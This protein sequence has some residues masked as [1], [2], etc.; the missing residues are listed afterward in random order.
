MQQGHTGLQVISHSSAPRA[1]RAASTHRQPLNTG[2]RSFMANS[3]SDRSDSAHEVENLL[4][5]KTVRG[6]HSHAGVQPG[7]SGWGADSATSR[8]VQQRRS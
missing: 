3:I 6:G 2:N 1:N 5:P 4:L 7:S 8:L